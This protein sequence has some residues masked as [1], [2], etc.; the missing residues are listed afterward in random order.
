MILTR[1]ELALTQSV[2]QARIE[3]LRNVVAKTESKEA[4]EEIF[5]CAVLRNKIQDHLLAP[6]PV[7]T[8]VSKAVR[9]LDIA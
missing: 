3:E 2:L 6:S 4:R 1:E 8:A 5:N 9:R 7:H